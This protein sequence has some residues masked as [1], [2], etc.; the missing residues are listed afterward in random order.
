MSIELDTTLAQAEV[1]FLSFRQIVQDIDRRQAEL[2]D[3]AGL[4]RRR[5]GSQDE[6]D[7]QGVVSQLKKLPHISDD[8]RAL[9]KQ[10]L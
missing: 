8:L 10:D 9:L 7:S 2:L 6:G 3:P 4:R 1:L 5:G